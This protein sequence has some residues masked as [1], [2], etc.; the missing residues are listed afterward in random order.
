MV[1]AAH[2]TLLELCEYPAGAG[3]E[4]ELE[5]SI[6]DMSRETS[7]YIM[8]CTVPLRKNGGRD[9]AVD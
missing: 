9:L 8:K 7:A 5:V 6:T 3:W 1:G 4:T 2:P